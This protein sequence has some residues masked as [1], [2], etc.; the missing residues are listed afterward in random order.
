MTEFTAQAV[1][2]LMLG[3]TYAIVALGIVLIFSVLDVMSLAQGQIL[4]ASGYVGFVTVLS[5]TG[6]LIVAALP[7]IAAGC[8]LGLAVE[9]VAVRPA[10]SGGH[11]ATLVT[12][13][14][15]GMVI[16]NVVVLIA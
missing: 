4:V 2:A 8:A 1:N 3:S 5:A 14:G 12:T 13:L 6:S 10:A 7:T 16:L 15:A 11:M 9:R